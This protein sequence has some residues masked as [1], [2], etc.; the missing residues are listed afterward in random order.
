MWIT[1]KN[2]R[3]FVFTILLSIIMTLPAIAQPS[4]AQTTGTARSNNTNLPATETPTTKPNTVSYGSMIEVIADAQRKSTLPLIRYCVE[5]QPAM[6]EELK[7]S[8]L[9]YGAKVDEATAPLITEYRN[10][11]EAQRSPDEFEKI[12]QQLMAQVKSKIER[13][14][15]ADSAHYCHWM[16]KQL[17]DIKVETFRAQLREGYN[18][19]K[20]IPQK[21]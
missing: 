4:T 11:P 2:V 6:K 19:M 8:F 7:E 16:I 14:T 9:A 13:L 21:E 15:I 17:G 3:T 18:L 10:D 20:K 1:K 12:E 5:Q